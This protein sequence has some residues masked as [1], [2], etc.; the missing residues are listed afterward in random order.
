MKGMKQNDQ[1]CSSLPLCRKT[2][3]KY[4]I[5][6][7]WKS[8]MV[9][10]LID[11]TNL[12]PAASFTQAGAPALLLFWMDL[13]R[14]MTSAFSYLLSSGDRMWIFFK[15]CQMGPYRSKM[16]KVTADFIPYFSEKIHYCFAWATPGLICINNCKH[17]NKNKVRMGHFRPTPIGG[18][19]HFAV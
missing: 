12:H 10:A 6:Q 15:Q 4:R 1:L 18:F 2:S 19:V 17:E 9:R 11:A 3:D 13:E 14:W 16:Q 5:V 8:L 7:D